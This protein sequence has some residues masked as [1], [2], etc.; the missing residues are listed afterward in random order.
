MDVIVLECKRDG[1][2]T[3]RYRGGFMQAVRNRPA[4]LKLT[5]G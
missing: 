1:K 4:R 3:D 5:D 2:M